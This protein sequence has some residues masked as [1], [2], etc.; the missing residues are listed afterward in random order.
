[1]IIDYYADKFII[2]MLED[3]KVNITIVTSSSSYLNKETI[4]NNITIIHN[5][6]IHDR[7]IFVDNTTYA[8]GTSFNEIGKKRFII[9]KLNNITK[10]MILK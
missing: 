6:T 7:F 1:M 9:M 8:I 2:S 5:D 3:I 10:E 4:P